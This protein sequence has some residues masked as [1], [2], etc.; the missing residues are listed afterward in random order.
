MEGRKTMDRVSELQM[1]DGK[2]VLDAPLAAEVAQWGGKLRAYLEGHHL[3]I[4]PAGKVADPKHPFISRYENICGGEPV[5]AG[6]RVTVR[7]I[8]EYDRLYHSIERILRALPHL[9]REQVEDALGYYAD[10]STEIDAYIAEN[11]RAF[12]EGARQA[13]KK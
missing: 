9:T 10:H 1:E 11:E 3:V 4:V 6:T 5:I 7:A 2:I 8:V 13:W 12:D